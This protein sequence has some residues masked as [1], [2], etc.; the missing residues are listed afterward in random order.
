M[1]KFSF[2]SVPGLPFRARRIQQH[3]GGHI[4]QLW[5][6]AQPD[7]LLDELIAK[8]DTHEDVIDERIPYW[9]ELWPSAIGM[10][11]YLL[12]HP[13]LVSGHS[14]LE[15]GCGLGL[16]GIAAGMLGGEVTLSDYLAPALDFAYANWQLN[17]HSSVGLALL[18]WRQPD[19]T[20][21]AD[22]VLASDITYEARH[23][24]YLPHAFRTLCRP[25]G[26][27][28]ISDPQRKVAQA[29]F[30]GLAG[31]GFRVDRTE[32]QVRL[33]E[34]LHLVDIYLISL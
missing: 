11:Q 8:G 16:P 21:T 20:L 9:A 1:S 24:S 6:V 29:F 2:A 10:V 14:V 31:E 27:V 18:D 34:R 17:H 3:V 23:F 19:P 33:N 4:F 28:L 25:G 26:H 30:Q 5:Q 32:E 15:I 22:L 13:E 7:Q 12:R